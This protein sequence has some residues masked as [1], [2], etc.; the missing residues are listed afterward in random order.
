M[1]EVVGSTELHDKY[2]AQYNLAKEEWN[3][4]YV[5]ADTCRLYTKTTT[6]ADGNQLDEPEITYYD[7]EAAYLLPLC[8]MVYSTKKTKQKQLKT[9]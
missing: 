7:T 3:A 9:M 4:C 5:E 8:V 1:A 2:A 6:D